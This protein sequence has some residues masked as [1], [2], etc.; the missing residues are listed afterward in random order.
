MS[1]YA[2]ILA[3]GALLGVGKG[4]R[5]VYS[6][7]VIPSYVR[8]ERLPTAS[9]LQMMANGLLLLTAGSRIGMLT[10]QISTSKKIIEVS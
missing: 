3:V 5:M 8:I 1:E 4:M 2:S 6:P 7:L 9:G 10:S